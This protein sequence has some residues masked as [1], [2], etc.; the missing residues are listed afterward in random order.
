MDSNRAVR[1]ERL[2]VSA[3]SERAVG[4]AHPY[5]HTQ[6][7]PAPET[8]GSGTS[9]HTEP[10]GFASGASRGVVGTNRRARGLD[11]PW[12]RPRLASLSPTASSVV[13]VVRADA[14]RAESSPIRSRPRR[15]CRRDLESRWGAR[16]DSDTPDC[17]PRACTTSDCSWSRIGR[18]PRGVTTT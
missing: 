6:T 1:R 15:S 17:P 10:A 2:C 8:S 5:L 3:G 18:S 7:C 13:W 16:P 12:V 9:T 14:A 11:G 4:R